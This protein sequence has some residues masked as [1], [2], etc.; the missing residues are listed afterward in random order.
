MDETSL[1]QILKDFDSRIKSA[2]TT[3]DLD[4]V[5]VDFIGKKGAV[6]S[7]FK[8]M[9]KINPDERKAYGEK[10]NSV[11]KIVEDGICQFENSLNAKLMNEK[12]NAAYCDVTLPGKFHESGHIHPIAKTMDDIVKVFERLGF[13][14][15]EGPDIET[16]YIN[17]DA[18]NMFDWHPARDAQDSFYISDNTVLRTHTSGVQ[19]RTMLNNKPPIKIVAPGRVYRFDEVDASHS[20]V[21][22]QIEGLL[23]D[24]VTNFAAFKGVITSFC[25]EFFGADR[26]VIFRSSYFPFTEPSAEVDVEC[27]AC[28]GKGCGVCKG[29]GFLEIMGAG[30]VHP[31]VLK[32]GNIDPEVYRGFAFGMGVERIAML[33]YGITD[34][35]DFYVNDL[36]L[37]EQF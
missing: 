32:N 10:I 9:G 1:S 2:V 19:V 29:S 13:S 34:I 4:A 23:V 37:C 12:L 11:K 3:A 14:V 22:H 30:M 8:E 15:S 35:R 5:K 33:K 26:K 16:D 6:T 36:R 27:F 7:L 20:P 17:F 31:N 25:K 18:L 21:F 24:K 28:G